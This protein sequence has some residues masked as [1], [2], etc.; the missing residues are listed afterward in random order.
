MG[1]PSGFFLFMLLPPLLGAFI[2]Q[3][4]VSARVR[5]KVII[6]T[7]VAWTAPVLIIVAIFGSGPLD[8][9]VRAAT[10]GGIGLTLASI[11]ALVGS[12]LSTLTGRLLG[13]RAS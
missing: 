8:I 5:A 2:I 1:D 10:F 11:G 9:L 3:F 12:E 7:A 6:W 13:R 4:F